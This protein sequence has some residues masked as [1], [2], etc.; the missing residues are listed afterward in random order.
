M[1]KW[2]KKHC[3]NNA[4]GALTE[5]AED[6]NTTKINNSVIV[7][8]EVQS[9][10]HD[11]HHCNNDSVQRHCHWKASFHVFD[12]EKHYNR[13]IQKC[14]RKHNGDN[15]GFPDEEGDDDYYS[16]EEE[17]GGDNYDSPD[18][19][20]DDLTKRSGG[21]TPEELG[22]RNPG[23][24]YPC[25]SAYWM[26]LCNA[27]NVW[28]IKEHIP[29]PS[30]LNCMAQCE[31]MHRADEAEKAEKAKQQESGGGSL[32]KRS[33]AVDEATT[34]LDAGLAN[35]EAEAEG[36]ACDAGTWANAWCGVKASWSWHRQKA[37]DECIDE[38]R[39]EHSLD[40]MVTKR[41][42]DE[43]TNND[44]I[45]ATSEPTSTSVSLNKRDDFPYNGQLG[46]ANDDDNHHCNNT[47]VQVKCSAKSM[48]TFWSY[49]KHYFRCI[50]KCVIERDGDNWTEG[51]Q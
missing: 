27:A 15:Y 32:G 4:D 10:N 50:A 16:P 28:T 42:D 47:W 6:T 38:C 44:A 30:Y 13:C 29:Q 49:K 19:E 14:V 43:T 24:D 1:A 41:S 9:D 26:T 36:G 37:F 22:I 35:M 33:G 8:R 46:E 5:R 23:L 7:E 45:L 25:D 17:E 3:S 39:R 31:E 34:V 48:F 12:K 2:S 11:N 40:A 51:E 18:K 21:I 20:G